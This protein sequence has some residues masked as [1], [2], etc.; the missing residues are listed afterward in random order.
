MKVETVTYKH[1]WECRHR[2][3][4]YDPVR[5]VQLCLL[6]LMRQ[7]PDINEIPPWCPLE[8]KETD[9]EYLIRKKKIVGY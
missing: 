1:C 4:S 2:K 9:K 7:I 6:S 3:A 5:T 8:D